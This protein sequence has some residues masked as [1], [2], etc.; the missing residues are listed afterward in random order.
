MKT[1]LICLQQEGFVEIRQKREIQPRKLDS[2]MDFQI[3]RFSSQT[4][5]IH[6]KKEE[7]VSTN[8]FK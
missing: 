2:K 4:F 1:N 3:S 6:Q 8:N 5:L 7:I